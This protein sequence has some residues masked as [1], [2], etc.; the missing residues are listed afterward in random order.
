MTQPD[1]ATIARQILDANI[2]MTLGTAD[3]NGQP[4]ASPVY[5]AVADYR[6][7]YWGSMPETQ[8]SRNIAVRPQ[9]SIV[10]FNSQAAISTGQAVYMS[11]AVEQVP[12][13]AVETGIGIFSQASL[14]S[15]GIAWTADRVQAPSH[16]RLYRAVVSE[17]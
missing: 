12:E 14:A 16:L 4:W 10:V 15:G 13:A 3:E 11:A 7:F 8:H 9:V 1:F 5:Y 6:Q 2:Y 17:P